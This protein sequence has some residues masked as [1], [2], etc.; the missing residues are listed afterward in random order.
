MIFFVV[1]VVIIIN[2]WTHC[3]FWHSIFPIQSNEKCFEIE[4]SSCNVQKQRFFAWIW[5]ITAVIVSWSFFPEQNQDLGCFFSFFL[6]LN[7]YLTRKC[8]VSRNF[9]ALKY[10]LW[11]CH[12]HQWW[13]EIRSDWLI[14]MEQLLVLRVCKPPIYS[15]SLLDS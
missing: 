14:W 6:G 7:I 9:I 4:L 2:L 10:S 1:V 12:P 8:C 5:W 3:M 15:N 11:V 13:C